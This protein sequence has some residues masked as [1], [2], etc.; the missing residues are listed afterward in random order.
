[1]RPLWFA[2]AFAPLAAQRV[3]PNCFPGLLKKPIPFGRTTAIPVGRCGLIL[4]EFT[5]RCRATM[6]I[7]PVVSARFGADDA[8][9]FRWRQKSAEAG[10]WEFL[11][12][13]VQRLRIWLPSVDGLPLRFDTRAENGQRRQHVRDEATVEYAM[14]SRGFLAPASVVH[15]RLADGQ[16]VTE[17]RYSSY[18][19]FQIFGADAKIKFSVTDPPNQ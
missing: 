9:L 2:L 14:T 4:L 5:S 12:R 13:Q 18:A 17:G 6:E 7:Q 11:G 1:M 15:R 10:G 19:P 3:P 8:L 16:I